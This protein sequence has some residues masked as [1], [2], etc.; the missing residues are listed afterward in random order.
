M[1]NIH[2]NAAKNHQ[3]KQ[4]CVKYRPIDAQEPRPSIE[5]LWRAL[6]TYNRIVVGQRAAVPIETAFRTLKETALDAKARYPHLD[7]VILEDGREMFP[8]TTTDA[9]H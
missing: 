6:G 4:F 5:A 7:V 8:A 2:F 1:K 3:T 9:I